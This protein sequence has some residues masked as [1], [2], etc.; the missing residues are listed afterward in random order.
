MP[1]KRLDHD[2]RSPE[3][4]EMDEMMRRAVEADRRL[5]L[6]LASEVV[7]VLEYR[8]KVERGEVPPPEPCLEGPPKPVPQFD[9]VIEG[10]RVVV[11]SRS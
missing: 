5:G 7:P 11:R 8:R 4:Q 2:P 9:A 3:E 1:I 6:D 10:S